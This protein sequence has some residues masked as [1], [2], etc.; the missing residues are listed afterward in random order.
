MQV[1]V[2]VAIMLVSM[3]L[4]LAPANA[5]DWPTRPVK[6][7]VSQGAGGTPDIICRLLSDRLSKALGQQFVVE[8]RPGGANVVGAHEAA[9]AAACSIVVLP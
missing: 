3:L 2:R 4:L 8:N 1:L 9:R 7:I 5:L 6:I